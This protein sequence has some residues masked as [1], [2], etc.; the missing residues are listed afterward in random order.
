MPCFCFQP[1]L[2]SFRDGLPDRALSVVH[3][4]GSDLKQAARLWSIPEYRRCL[5]PEIERLYNQ[6]CCRRQVAQLVF[7]PVSPHLL[8]V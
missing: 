2:R 6:I 1:H 4:A 3:L 8:A 7:C 5:T